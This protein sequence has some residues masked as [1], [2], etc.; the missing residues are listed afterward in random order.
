[1]IAVRI[2]YIYI[3]AAANGQHF[4]LNSYIQ[5]A[6]THNR[7]HTHNFILCSNRRSSWVASPS[8]QRARALARAHTN[9]NTRHKFPRTPIE[10][11][12]CCANRSW[13]NCKLNEQH[14]LHQTLWPFN[15]WLATANEMRQTKLDWNEKKSFSRRSVSIHHHHHQTSSP[16]LAAPPVSVISVLNRNQNVS[17]TV[18]IETK[19]NIKK[20][21]EKNRMVGTANWPFHYYYY[22]YYCYCYNMRWSNVCAALGDLL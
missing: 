7:N 16:S 15:H 10:S 5:T 22:D 12:N 1:M 8:V 9:K 18:K 21:M 6:E 2:V 3:C 17:S 14:A 11:M 4:S 19:W 20:N 13:C